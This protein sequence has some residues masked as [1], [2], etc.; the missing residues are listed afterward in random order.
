[1]SLLNAVLFSKIQEV[2]LKSANP[3]LELPE[4][5]LFVKEQLGEK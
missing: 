5:M 2:E 1:M 4:A 3:C